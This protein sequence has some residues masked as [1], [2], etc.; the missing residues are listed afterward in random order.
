SAHEM[1]DTYIRDRGNKN[2]N[3]LEFGVNSLYDNPICKDL[4]NDYLNN[5]V[6]FAGSWMVRLPERNKEALQMFS[7]VNRTEKKLAIVDRQYERRMSRHHYPSYLIKNISATIPHERLMRLHKATNWGINLNSV[8]DS[9]TMF[10]NR[11]Y[12]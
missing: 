5:I 10:A 9:V 8:K 6:T 11:V 2:V 3:Y 7:A 4:S 1:V 12:E